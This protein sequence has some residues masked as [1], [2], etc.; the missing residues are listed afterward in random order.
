VQAGGFVPLAVLR[1]DEV[2]AIRR[3]IAGA[4]PPP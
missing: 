1:S 3:S 4:P 2:D